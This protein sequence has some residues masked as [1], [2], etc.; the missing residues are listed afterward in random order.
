M[1]FKLMQVVLLSGKA[2]CLQAKLIT[3]G[4]KWC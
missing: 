3:L 1:H 4:L 2:V